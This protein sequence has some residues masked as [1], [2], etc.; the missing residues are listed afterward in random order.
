MSGDLSC[1]NVLAT[2]LGWPLAERLGLGLGL[3]SR[4]F[5]V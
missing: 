5:L 1:I 4:S 2:N 3:G